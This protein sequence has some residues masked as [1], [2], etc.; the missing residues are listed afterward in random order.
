MNISN[1]RTRRLQKLDQELK[2]HCGITFTS[3]LSLNFKN[4]SLPVSNVQ[5]VQQWS[6]Y[7]S[8]WTVAK[9]KRPLFSKPSVWIDTKVQIV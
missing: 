3:A 1:G 8:H 2:N 4:D 6:F 5:Y 7:N 9:L